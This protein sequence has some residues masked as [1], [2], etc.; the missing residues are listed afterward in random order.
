MD[1]LSDKIDT[2][3]AGQADIQA[4]LHHKFADIFGSVAKRDRFGV[5]TERSKKHIAKALDHARRALAL[6]RQFYGER[7]ELVAKDMVYLYWC[8]GVEEKGRA[9]YLMAAINMMR[10]TNPNNLNLPYMLEDYTNRLMMPE[11]F[12]KYH[13]QYRNAVFPPTVENKY[14]IGERYL[15]EMLPV[16][17]LHYKQDNR[18][19]FAAE[20]SLAYTLAMQEKW[21]D[22][23]EHFS[24]CKQS[25]G[26]ELDAAVAKGLKELAAV[27]EKKLAGK[28][29]NVSP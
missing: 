15:R 29:R 21:T 18:A 7:H 26:K 25:E 22:F 5:L 8:G 20:C 10:E 3:F 6:R 24:L 16:F 13:E 4:E 12:E 28:H 23:D 1:D 17:R 2:D 9:T 14:Q 11:T 19:I 27:I